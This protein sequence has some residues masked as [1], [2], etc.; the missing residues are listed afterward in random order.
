MTSVRDFSE[1]IE[2]AHAEYAAA[3]ETAAS[4]YRQR[5]RELLRDFLGT[6]LPDDPV[7]VNGHARG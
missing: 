2:K 7:E 6:E 4:D 3:T 1:A 5:T